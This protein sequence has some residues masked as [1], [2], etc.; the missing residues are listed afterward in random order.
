M[1]EIPESFNLAK[2]LDQTVKNKVIK[3]VVAAQSPHKFAFYFNDNPESY[4]ALL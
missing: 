4:N 1:L 2:Q 3:N